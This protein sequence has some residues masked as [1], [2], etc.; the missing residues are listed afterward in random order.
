MKIG[1]IGG[2]GMLGHHLAI[3]AQLRQYEVVIIHRKDS[4][5]SHIKDLQF[6]SRI[7]DLNDR[8]SMIR[9]MEG[10]DYVANCAAYYPTVPKPLAQ[11]IKTARLQMQFFIDGVREAKVSRALYVGGSIVLPKNPNG[12][13]HE[14]LNYPQEPESTNAYLRV[15][16]LM[17]YMAKINAEDGLP[18]VI[19]I[20]SMT[21]GEYDYAPTTGRLIQDVANEE[22]PAYVHG[23]RN[24]VYAGDAARGLLLALEKG[25][26]GERYLI[27]GENTSIEEII[28]MIC[29]IA[30]VPMIKKTI[31]LN[32]AKFISKSQEIKYTLFRGSPPTLSSTAVAILAYGQHLDGSKA[33]E[34]LGYEPDLT[35]KDAI[36]R[37]YN[38]FKKEGYIE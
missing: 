29:E 33:K 26:F 17:D 34:E 15:K 25:R 24:A 10:L 5:L 16:W 35:V 28:K 18:I 9:A 32:M 31:P 36:E 21:F 22:I 7:A 38:W 20:P 19:G 11:E 13:G 12:L 6:E 2:T 27:T 23:L 1:I 37:A 30:Q 4:N 3:A 8:G 14:S